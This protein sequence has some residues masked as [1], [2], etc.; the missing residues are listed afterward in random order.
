M[1]V[2][3]NDAIAARFRAA[4]RIDSLLEWCALATLCER[5]RQIADALGHT[6]EARLLAW[7]VR[8]ARHRAK[9]LSGSTHAN[10]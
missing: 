2:L 10:A 1:S 6:A 7:R 9:S 8:L 5:E 3:G 4:E